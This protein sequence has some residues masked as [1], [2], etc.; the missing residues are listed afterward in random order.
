MESG[1]VE[2]GGVDQFLMRV[3]HVSLRESRIYGNAGAVKSVCADL[4]TPFT[5]EATV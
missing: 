2:S 5:K 1:R 3:S 4:L